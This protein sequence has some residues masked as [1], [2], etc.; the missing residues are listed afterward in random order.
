[1][2]WSL[3]G[4]DGTWQL[5]VLSLNEDEPGIHESILHDGTNP[6]TTFAPSTTFANAFWIGFELQ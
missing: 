5:C 2:V 4:N 1:M 3:C 6:V